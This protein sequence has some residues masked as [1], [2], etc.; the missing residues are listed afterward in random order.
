MGSM[1][2][3]KWTN[4]LSKD[5]GGSELSGSECAEDQGIGLSPTSLTHAFASASV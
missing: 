3:S 1:S 5:L 2:Q 4:G